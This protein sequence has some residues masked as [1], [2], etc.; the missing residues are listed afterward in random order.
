MPKKNGR[1]ALQE[2]REDLN[3]RRIPIVIMTTSQREEDILHSYDLGAN[4]V[5]KKPT[6]FDSL[7]QIVRTLSRYWFEIIDLP[8][9]RTEHG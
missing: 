9:E 4:S 7:V 3:L 8:F 1:E 5:I 2:I 6:D